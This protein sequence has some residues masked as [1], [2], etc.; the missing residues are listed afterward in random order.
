MSLIFF[1]GKIA[2]TRSVNFR[3]SGTGRTQEISVCWRSQ[4][5]IIQSFESKRTK[6]NHKLSIL[7]S[8]IQIPL[9]TFESFEK[10]YSWCWLRLGFCEKKT[11][12]LSD[13]FSRERNCH[14]KKL[15]NFAKLQLLNDKI[16]LITSFAKLQV[17]KDLF[18]E[19][20]VSVLQ[21]NLAVW[22]ELREFFFHKISTF[23]GGNVY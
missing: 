14:K 12:I 1:S 9:R 17:P 3:A 15:R 16:D 4:R 7:P 18:L 23:S 20:S 5:T 19:G 11:T 22:V 8:G 13:F 2:L 10:T 21:E 6:E